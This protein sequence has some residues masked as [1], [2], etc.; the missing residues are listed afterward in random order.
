MSLGSTISFA[1]K[2]FEEGI[3]NRED[4]GG[5]DLK[6]GNEEVM[7]PLIEKIV[8]REGIGD[9]LADGSKAASE[10]FGPESKQFLLEVKGQEIPMHDPRLRTGLGLQYA[11]SMN[12][13]DHIFAQ[14]DPYFVNKDSLGVKTCAGIGL[15]DPVDALDL[16]YQ[17]VRLVLYTSYLIG[18]Y[19]LLGACFFGYAVR[20]STSLS[21]LLEIVQAVTGWET[22][23]WELLK[24]GERSLAMAK[25]FNARQGIT[26]SDDRLPDKLFTSLKGGPLDGKNA[27]SR[28]QFSEAIKLYYEMAGWDVLTGRPREAKLYELNLEWLVE[29]R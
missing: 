17:K 28:E 1:M 2:C 10:K 9:I 22:S 23:W 19:D 25:E 29:T 27:L 3:I 15:T 13:A 7:L 6:F 4:T 12:G 26:F 5:L 18:V 20:G 24:A 11:L 21:T 14:H 16:G 8:R